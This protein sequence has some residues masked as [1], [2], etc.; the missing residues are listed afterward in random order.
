MS[1]IMFFLYSI[2]IKLYRRM[3]PIWLK[4]DL[5]VRRYRSNIRVWK[6]PLSKLSRKEK[7]LFLDAWKGWSTDSWRFYKA[8]GCQL[9]FG[10]VP[11]DYYQWAEHVLNRRWSSFFLQ[12]KCCL[13]RF[14]PS[15]NRPKTI[16]QKIDGHFV[17]EENQELSVT[18]A[19]QILQAKKIF[20]SKVALGSGG[21]R[22][23][24][25]INLQRCSTPDSLLDEIMRPNDM[26]YQEVLTQS[27]FMSSFNPESINTIRMLTLNINEKC[28]V[29][30]SFLRM[31]GKGSFVDNLSSGGG[32]LVGIDSMGRVNGFGIDKTYNKVYVSTAGQPFAGLTI[33]RWQ[34]IKDKVCEFHKHIPY[35]N[36]IGWD[37][38]IAEDD[39]P[40]I[41]EINLDS[42]EIEAH[43]VF[44]GPVFGERLEEVR[45]YIHGREPFIKHATIVY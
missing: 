40:I 38:A 25:L 26:L 12:H 24:R 34:T 8:F 11:N 29:L 2:C 23:V 36:L 42:A 1:S 6:F 19:R 35:A 17:T 33:P 31:G 5:A 14:I 20:V 37:I 9:D 7:S 4:W 32:T 44:N 30:S 15:C 41:I 43:Q 13:K 21:G 3:D 27:A 22:G 16:L 10:Y 39:T 28:T 18:E 45:E